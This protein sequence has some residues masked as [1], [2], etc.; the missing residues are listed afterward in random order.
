MSFKM[1]AFLRIVFCF[2][3]L[4]SFLWGEKSERPTN[5]ILIFADDLGI[6]LLGCYGQEL[7]G[8]P[9]IDRLASEGIKYNNYYGGVYCAP[10]RWSLL[11]GMHDG[12]ADAWRHT[13]SGLPIKR[14]AG[15][16]TEEEFQK[17]LVEI[18]ESAVPIPDHEVFLGQVAQKAGHKTAQFGK[19]DN[20]FSTWMERVERY[21]WD[22][23]VGY[24]D[25]TRAHGFYPPYLWRDGERFRL[26]GNKLADCGKMSEKGDEPVG[27]GGETYSQN[28]FI[29]EILSF[30]RENKDE[31]FFIYHPTQLPHGPVAIPELHPDF[32]DDPSLSLAEKKYASMVKMLDDHVGL[33]MQELKEQ[34]IDENTAVF[35][36]SDNGHELYYGPKSSYAK[37]LPNGDKANLTDKKWR[38]SEA[39]D[40]FDGSDGR[41]GL[42]RSG[43][44]GGMQCPMIVRWPG[45][46]EAGIET[47]HFSAHFDFMATLADMLGV[48]LPEGKDGISYL[49]T[50]LGKKQKEKHEYVVVNNHFRR[51]GGAALITREGWKLVEVERKRDE[52]Q[53]YDLRRDNEER[54]DLASKYPKKVEKLKAILLREL[55]SARPDL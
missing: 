32:E 15:E 45:R 19:I 29:E 33:I 8:T 51:M 28:V 25:H 22:H 9:H 12:R 11:S 7:I 42:K 36:T 14:D 53:L 47:D 39:G 1:K 49:P 48:D 52:F 50:L 37:W 54:V 40:V 24:Y 35:F 23:H 3:V 34:G 43:Y 46:I 16:I 20:G 10:S 13:R 17:G 2:V 41:A 21:G 4:Q 30:I 26:K 55:E 27:S 18:K 6:G 5:V 44:Q 38:T 31:S